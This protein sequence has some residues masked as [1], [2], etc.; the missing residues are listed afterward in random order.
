MIRWL[1]VAAL[2]GCVDEY[3]VDVVATLPQIPAACE[4]LGAAELALDIRPTDEPAFTLTAAPCSDQLGG[5]DLAGFSATISR[6]T[7]GF[8]RVVATISDGSGAPIGSISTVFSTQKPLVLAFQRGDL[9]G[10]PTAAISVAVAGCAPD[11][12]VARVALSATPALASVPSATATIDCTAPAPAALTV[13]VGPLTLSAIGTG[14]DGSACWAGS[15][16][17]TATD[18]AALAIALTRSCP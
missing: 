2:A 7:A 17:A 18:A 9:P 14:S 10:W 8:P 16:D 11:G 6:V 3:D 13:P 15:L 12:P 4:T 1:L 5:E